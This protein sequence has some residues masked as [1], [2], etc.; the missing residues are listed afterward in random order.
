[1]PRK[2]NLVFIFSDQQRWDTM[3]C[4]GNEWIE[5]PHLNALSDRSFV[6]ENA[7]VTQPVCTP[8]RASIMTG[9][10]PHTAGP[11][12]NRIALPS[13]VRSIA[14]M[15][16][17]DYL[18]AYYGKWHLGNDSAPQH[19]FTEWIGTEDNKRETNLAPNMPMSPYYHHL[20]ENGFE[21]QD[22][23]SDG[24]R[25]F[26]ADQRARLPEEFQM[27][28]YLGDRAAEFIEANAD[29]PF[30]LY[31]STYEPHPPYDGPLNDLYEP[32]EL[33]IGPAFLKRPNGGSAFAR[34]RA[35]YFMQ[36][37][38]GADPGADEYIT[39]NAGRGHDVT[40]EAG[41]RRLRAQYFANITL[42]D[43]M[44]GKITAAL[45][46]AGIE[47]H[48]ALVFTSDHGEM[49]GDHGMLEK[50][51]FYEESAR[52]PLMVRVPWL[53]TEQRR[54]GGSVGHVDLVPTLLDL[55]GE[56]VPGHLQGASRAPVLRG[57]ASLDGNDV[58]MEWSGVGAIDDRNL[59]SR[60]INRANRM[61]WRS[62]VSS[63]W[64]LNLCAAD[65]CELFDL[66]SDP[67][68]QV[69]VFDDPIQK[70]RIQ[71]LAARIRRWQRETGDDAAL[72]DL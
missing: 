62:I 25:I 12:V 47:N 48:T 57:D 41:W 37:L 2:R 55:L 64:K 14:E 29:R 40:T 34:A 19:G 28:S 11:I 67:Y 22:V 46:R 43:R 13:H 66:D 70:D 8:A 24:S 17:D 49:A 36:F 35:D 59:G 50:R 63:R 56:P 38:D 9:L 61:P 69:N 27:A 21:P 30:M 10:Y 31:V 5:T 58:F 54:I 68:E 32:A 26:G 15:V 1:M 51:M 65:Q 20:V 52:V 72:P 45:E 16:S 39:R 6:F 71:D 7:Y 44:V 53:S 3:R 4:Y 42:V 33:P 60:E 23:G 18:R